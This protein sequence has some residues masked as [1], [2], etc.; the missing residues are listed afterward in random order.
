MLAAQKQGVQQRAAFGQG[1]SASLHKGGKQASKR[2]G[3]VNPPPKHVKWTLASAA[4]N[5][6][7]PDQPVPTAA[8][9]VPGMSY[10]DEAPAVGGQGTQPRVAPKQGR[11]AK[12]A[13]VATPMEEDD[14]HGDFQDDKTCETEQRDQVSNEVRIYFNDLNLGC[15]PVCYT[16]RGLGDSRF[17]A[18]FHALLAGPAGFWTTLSK[19]VFFWGGNFGHFRMCLESFGHSKVV[20]D[21]INR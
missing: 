10:A 15:A 14:V 18:V 4:Q 11:P 12:K 21:N 19:I 20:S 5:T 8:R 16:L 7:V 13:P 2:P 9:E 6:P 17:P 3:L 1:S